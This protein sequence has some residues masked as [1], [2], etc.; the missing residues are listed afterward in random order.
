MHVNDRAEVL[1]LRGESP[2]TTENSIFYD[3]GHRHAVEGI[4]EYLPE[5]D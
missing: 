1:E 2:M 5:F 3:G 4:P